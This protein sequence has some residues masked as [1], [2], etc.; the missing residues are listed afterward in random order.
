M[1]KIFFLLS[2]FIITSALTAQN[3]DDVVKNGDVMPE[4]KLT[5]TVNGNIDSKDLKGK[6]VM[7]TIFATW[8]PPCQLELAEIK[9][10]LWPKYK[11]NPKFVM[12]TVGR[13]HSDEELTKYNEKKGFAFPLYPDPKRDFTSKFATK[14]IPRSYLVDETG[15]IIYTSLGFQKTEFEKL[16]KILEEKLNK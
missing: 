12:L 9:N 11:D 13:E 14:S 16:M 4:F 10:E 1:K 15:K 8:C 6:I 3:A 2:I 5:S 7:I